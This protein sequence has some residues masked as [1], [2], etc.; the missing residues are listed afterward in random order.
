[1]L[2][3]IKNYFRGNNTDDES[4]PLYIPSTRDEG[5]PIAMVP[6]QHNR[7]YIGIMVENMCTS[8]GSTFKQVK[9]PELSSYFRRGN[10]QNDEEEMTGPIPFPKAFSDSPDEVK[11]ET[12][13][14]CMGQLRYRPLIQQPEASDDLEEQ[15][16]ILSDAKYYSLTPC[17]HIYHGHCL[18]T[19]MKKSQKEH[20][21]TCRAKL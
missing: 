14:I 3:R 2:A 18:A 7:S 12:C 13:A 20:C 11:N 6:R 15:N 19:W 16:E 21:P 10:T 9:M 17:K 8:I 5:I 4:L 1:M